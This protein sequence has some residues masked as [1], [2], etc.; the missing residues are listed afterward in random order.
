MGQGEFSLCLFC[1]LNAAGADGAAAVGQA[2]RNLPGVGL[3]RAD[4][5]EY[6]F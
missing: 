1:C 6:R 5:S 4:F 3:A 2:G